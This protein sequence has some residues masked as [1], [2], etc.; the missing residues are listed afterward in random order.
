MHFLGLRVLCGRDVGESLFDFCLHLV[1]IDISDYDYGLEVR[2][3]PCMVEICQAF[4]LESLEV[5]LASDE[6]AV[7][8][9]GAFVVGLLG[10]LIH[11]P[12]GISPRPS[13]FENHAPFLVDFGRVACHEM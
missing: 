2:T 5:L 9:F 1:H 6:G 13:L 10:L 12:L 4:R 8:I 11:S 7:S 3:I